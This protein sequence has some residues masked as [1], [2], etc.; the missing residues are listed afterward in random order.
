MKTTLVIADDV[1]T[2]LREEAARQR[3]TLSEMVE[4]ALRLLLAKRPRGRKLPPLPTFRGGRFL[5][6]VADRD[7]LYRAMEGR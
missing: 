3:R 2:R 7:A 5:V 6:D 1:M 4:A